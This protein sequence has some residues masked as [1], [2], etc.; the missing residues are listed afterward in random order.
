M[1]IFPRAI[2]SRVSK[3]ASSL[4]EILPH[5]FFRLS[6]SQSREY[7]SKPIVVPSNA[8]AKALLDEAAHT[9]GTHRVTAVMLRA[10]RIAIRELKLC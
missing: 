8:Q 6:S 1:Y 4:G 5:V 2:T 7:S 10:E 9:A 3:S